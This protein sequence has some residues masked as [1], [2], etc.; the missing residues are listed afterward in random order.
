VASQP[1]PA[2]PPP[3]GPRPAAQGSRYL[4]LD[5]G[6]RTVKARKPMG[7]SLAAMLGGHAYFIVRCVD[8]REWRRHGCLWQGGW[9]TVGIRKGDTDRSSGGRAQDI[10]AENDGHRR[11]ELDS[12]TLEELEGGST[13]RHTREREKAPPPTARCSSTAAASAPYR[14]G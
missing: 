3:R 9:G 7:K 12:S 8:A 14:E 6:V 13:D 2:P 4:G 11:L 5:G 1:L 10:K